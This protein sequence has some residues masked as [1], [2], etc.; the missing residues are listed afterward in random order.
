[1]VKLLALFLFAIGCTT[2]TYAPA[3][4]APGNTDRATFETALAYW[5]SCGADVAEAESAPYAMTLGD[6]GGEGGGVQRGGL[7]TIDY[8]NA[9]D[10]FV[11]A[12]EMGHALGLTHAPDGV[13]S[14]MSEKRWTLDA[15]LSADVAEF[16]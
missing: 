16:R 15:P 12:H 14:A 7:I 1:M 10:V 13:P 2:V 4:F 3:E 8:S 11:Y 6:L 5:R 9:L